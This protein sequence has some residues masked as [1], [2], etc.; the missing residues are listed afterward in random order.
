M[1]HL[2]RDS[3]LAR[4][5]YHMSLN[6]VRQKDVSEGDWKFSSLLEQV[7][8]KNHLF[9]GLF[10]INGRI[11][12]QNGDYIFKLN[13]L[14]K[15]STAWDWT[16]RLNTL[17]SSKIELFKR[18]KVFSHKIICIFGSVLT[19]CVLLKAVKV[20]RKFQEVGRWHCIKFTCMIKW[21]LP[22]LKTSVK[23][24]W[25]FPLRSEILLKQLATSV[26]VIIVIFND[27]HLDFG[28]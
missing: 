24:S 17:E 19:I 9:D 1:N 5:N 18:E 20:W 7:T 4:G 15:I 28:D 22:Q 16:Q 27:S 8:Y 10:L 23:I 26:S 25:I 21:N 13:K 2:S 14:S 6:I 11:V 12:F 3:S